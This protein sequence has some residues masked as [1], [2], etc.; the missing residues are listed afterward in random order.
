MQST[1]VRISVEAQAVALQYGKSVS[2]GIMDMES[3]LQ[4]VTSV[5]PKVTNPVTQMP[6]KSVTQPSPTQAY[7]HD[8]AY[9]ARFADEVRAAIKPKPAREIIVP[10]STLKTIGKIG[11]EERLEE[12]IGKQGRDLR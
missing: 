4:K 11:P 1:T 6:P 10:A 3:R 5:S 7:P 8:E 9:W 2:Q 12:P